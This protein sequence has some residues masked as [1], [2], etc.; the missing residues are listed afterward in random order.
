MERSTS[1]IYIHDRIASNR[2][3][4]I[5]LLWCVLHHLPGEELKILVRGELIAVN[6]GDNRTGWKD[7]LQLFA[8]FQLH[9]D[10]LRHNLNLLLLLRL[11]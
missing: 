4:Q 11:L 2:V 10:E 5:H 9:V 1:T 3:D 6:V 8:R 7:V